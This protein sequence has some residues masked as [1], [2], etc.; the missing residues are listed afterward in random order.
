MRLAPAV[1]PLLTALVVSH[2]LVAQLVAADDAATA[3]AAAAAPRPAAP[4][5]GIALAHDGNFTLSV[6]GSVVATSGAV[7]VQAARPVFTPFRVPLLAAR[8]LHATDLCA[9]WAARSVLGS[10]VGVRR[11][12][13]HSLF[14]TASRMVLL[15]ILVLP[16]PQL[17]TALCRLRGVLC[18][19]C[20]RV[21]CAPML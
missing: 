21:V 17:P 8:T 4:Q 9:D 1:V 2:L 5:L 6:G 19:H 7:I 11:L 20:A 14:L 13:H 15:K 16:W 10:W 18:C 3:A 12:F